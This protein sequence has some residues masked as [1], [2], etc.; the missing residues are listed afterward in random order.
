MIAFGARAPVAYIVLYIIIL[1]LLRDDLNLGYKILIASA[2]LII[3]GAYILLQNQIFSM[4]STMPLFQNSYLLRTFQ[5]G[6]LYESSTRNII[7]ENCIQ[8]IKT[9]GFFVGGFFGDRPYCGSV[10]PHNIFL[11]II[12]SWGWIIG[13]GMI[14][15]LIMLIIKGLGYKG[16]YKEVT[17]FAI[18]AELSRYFLSGTY[19]REPKFWIALF[20][21]ISV[22]KRT[23]KKT[24]QE[25]ESDFIEDRNNNIPQSD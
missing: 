1:E 5:K 16:I 11:E 3:G 12:M 15:F 25:W 9:M 24:V 23:N 14:L 4:L 8:R 13:S 6:S 21:L 22:S 7:W 18:F 20:I 17:I 19:V 2:L 10:Y